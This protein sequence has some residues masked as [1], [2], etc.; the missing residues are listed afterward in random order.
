MCAYVY[1]LAQAV[2]QFY[3]ETRILTEP[4]EEKQRGYIALIAMA[5]RAMEEC[6]DLLGFSAPDKM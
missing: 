3:H 5:K 4:D 6:I 1:E 2:N